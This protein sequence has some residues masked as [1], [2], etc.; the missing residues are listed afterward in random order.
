MN[1]H[2]FFLHLPPPPIHTFSHPNSCTSVSGK[3]K[4]LFC[5][6]LFIHFW[7]WYHPACLFWTNKTMNSSFCI[8]FG[9]SLSSR[10]FSTS[11]FT[12]PHPQAT[13][14]FSSANGEEKWA[15]VSDTENVSVNK[16]N[17]LPSYS[18]Y[19]LLE[20]EN[21]QNNQLN[22]LLEK[23]SWRVKKNEDERIRM[24]D[25]NNKQNYQ[26]RCHWEDI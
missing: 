8:T 2:S 15:L 3:E 19:F 23:K 22:S 12:L 9:L 26:N 25:S 5:Q 10:T 18:F 4:S 17:F 6:S 7:P 21:K 24:Q 11:L 13:F 1:Q 14:L 16:T 20:L